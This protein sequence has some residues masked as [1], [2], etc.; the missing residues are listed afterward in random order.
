M[1]SYPAL[2]V[3]SIANAFGFAGFLAINVPYMSEIMGPKVRPMVMMGCQVVCIFLLLVILA[4]IVPHYLFPG[5]YRTYLWILTGLNV[6]VALLFI[7]RLP[8]SPRWLEARERFAQ[9]RAVVERMEARVARR[10]PDLPEPDLTP[11]QVV[12]EEKTSPFAVFGKRYWGVTTFLLVV[13]VLGYGGIVYGVGSQAFL[14]LEENRGYSAGFIFAL[15]AWAGVAAVYLLNAFFGERFERKYTQLVGAVLF[16]G[17]RFGIYH[18]HN[19]T[20]VYVLYILSTVGTILWLWSMYAYIP[21]NYPTRMRSLGTGWTDGVGHL[22]AW[23][24]VLLAGAVFSAATP[25]GWIWLITIPGALVPAVMI[26]VF[27][28]SQRRRALEEIAQ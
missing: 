9:A 14:F 10:H 8:E 7:W 27:R 11:Y 3:L 5:Q 17:S 16:A 22:G 6:A 28:Q 12:A 24:G 19:T 13:M 23:G 2:I 18:V 26:A 25:V 20:G 1:T 4:G 15:T 21:I